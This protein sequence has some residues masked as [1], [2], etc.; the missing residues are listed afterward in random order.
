MVIFT[1]PIPNGLSFC[2][3]LSVF[4]LLC[5]HHSPSNVMMDFFRTLCPN[6]SFLISPKGGEAS[7]NNMQ[8]YCIKRLL[9][10]SFKRTT[11][12]K[13][14]PKF[15]HISDDFFP[16]FLITAFSYL[17]KK[18]WENQY[19]GRGMINDRSYCCHCKSLLLCRMNCIFVDLVVV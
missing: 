18:F 15:P 11:T 6:S 7:N 8:Y 3:Y 4:F 2:V 12:Q 17:M 13:R 10:A 5:H 9:D 14:Q 16:Y 1:S 19:Q